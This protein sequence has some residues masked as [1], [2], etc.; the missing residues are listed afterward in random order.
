VSTAVSQ[1]QALE[2]AINAVEHYMKALTLATSSKDRNLLDAKCKEWLTKAEKI[3][4]ADD[5]QSA[6]R[7][8]D[9][10]PVSRPLTSARKLTTREE[11]IILEGAKLNGFIFPPWKADPALGEFEKTVDG[12]GAFTYAQYLFC[13]AAWR[14]AGSSSNGVL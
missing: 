9:K 11:I 1:P 13:V 7:S 2:A 4:K 10:R 5:W 8:R 6:A 14:A 3:K 12:D